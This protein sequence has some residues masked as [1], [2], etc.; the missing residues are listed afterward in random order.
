MCRSRLVWSDF[1]PT[2]ARG[3]SWAPRLLVFIGLLA[4]IAAEPVS[5]A[6]GDWTAEAST[7]D[8]C[9]LTML[10]LQGLQQDHQLGPLNLGVTVRSNRATLW[11]TVSTLDL[12]QR[13]EACI[14]D[15]PGIAAVTNELRIEKPRETPAD[16]RPRSLLF[17][18]SPPAEESL[19]EPVRPAT[20]TG[21]AP[22]ALPR[23]GP[24]V[25]PALTIPSPPEQSAK[26]R[27]LIARLDQLR[28]DDLRYRGVSWEVHEGEVRLRGVVASSAEVMEFARAIAHLPGVR[29]VLL[30][31]LRTSAEF[32][33]LGTGIR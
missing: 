19:A 33:R 27:E 22:E 10:A 6:P 9:R 24:P 17:R 11:G 32:Q 12:S 14:E 4:G 8:D 1:P 2:F 5:P 29:R 31:E 20:L 13:A 15:V 16:E 26:D 23:D 7:L 25:M 18:P 21:R 30:D 3:R 28:R